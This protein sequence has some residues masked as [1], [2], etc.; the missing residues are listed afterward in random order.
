MYKNKVSQ[1]NRAIERLMTMSKPSEVFNWLTL[2]TL[3]FG[4]GS[5]IIL[6]NFLS[7]ISPHA[8]IAIGLAFILGAEAY[9]SI[10]RTGRKYDAIY[11]ESKMR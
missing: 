1:G 2:G 3:L 10:S 9:L 4:V 8:A 11:K 5:G 7:V 6:G